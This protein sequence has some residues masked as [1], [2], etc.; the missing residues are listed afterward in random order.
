MATTTAIPKLTY[1]DL[2]VIAKEREGD[3]QELFEGTL[4]VTPS[5]IPPHQLVSSRLIRWV[6]T[7]VETRDLGEIFPA[8]IDV[9]FAPGVVAVPDLVFVRRDRLEIVGAQAID[10]APDLI[11]EVLSPSTRR[12]D[13]G[14]KK[15]C[16]SDSACRSTGWWT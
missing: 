2:A 3:R 10:G 11:V 16:T 14:P 13:L 9:R 1:D 4:V 12:R 15:P 6:G 5:P 7:H 8:P